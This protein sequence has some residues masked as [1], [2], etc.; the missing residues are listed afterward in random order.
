MLKTM[1]EARKALGLS[2]MTLSE[3]IDVNQA[4][5]SL[6]ESGRRAP[7]PSQRMKIIAA[8]GPIHFFIKEEMHMPN[9][10][11]TVLEAKWDKNGRPDFSHLRDE[12]T[13]RS[14]LIT[15]VTEDY[16]HRVNEAE[17]DFTE[18]KLVYP[19]SLIYE[20]RV[21]GQSE[22][23]RRSYIVENGQASLLEDGERVPLEEY[24]ILSRRKIATL[25]VPPMAAE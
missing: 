24:S 6:I 14:Q 10:V 22:I 25:G 12:E 17:G 2:Q 19:D 1:A 13:I 23:F 4:L 5:L 7:T 18:V 11:P 9:N 8:L 3:M 20:V 21:D 15:L 16:S